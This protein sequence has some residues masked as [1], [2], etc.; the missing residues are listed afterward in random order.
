M[1]VQAI[2]RLGAT[3]AV[4]AMA[5]LTGCAGF[6]PPNSTTTSTGTTTSGDYVYALNPSTSTLSAYT[7]GS[8]TL[9]AIS[10]SPYTLASTVAPLSVCVS[11]TNSF[12]YVAGTGG[13][14]GYLIGTGG[15]L[16]QISSGAA[17]ATTAIGRIDCSPDGK[18]LVG[19]DSTNSQVDEY[20]INTSTGILT[21]ETPES[22]T[23]NQNLSTT[24]GAIRF[25]PLAG[26][27]VAALGSQGTAVYTFNTSTGALAYQGMAVPVST[28][29]SHNGIAINSTD[30]SLYIATSGSPSGV[31]TCSLGT[32]NTSC[33]T[34]PV[35]AGT[36]P[37]AVQ[38]SSTNGFLYVAN[39]GTS[40]TSTAGSISQYSFS[41]GVPTAL[42]PAS[43]APGGYVSTLARD[44]SGSY[45]LAGLGSTT[46]DLVLYSYST[47]TTGTLTGAVTQATS[48]ANTGAGLQIATTH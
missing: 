16:T 33:G 24:L 6:F 40:A 35:A 13:I 47:S 14:Y 28:L 32:S 15:V 26:Y 20:A 7:I 5:A 21:A 4:A 22:Y 12:V 10:G 36:A 8:G 23:I 3:L 2:K 38:L 39:F 31:I 29:V 34:T 41:G 9:T 19:L 46:N 43:V 48:T 11:G 25:S 1:K 27:V 18:W 44:N 17:L 30:Q 42:S 45:I 37:R